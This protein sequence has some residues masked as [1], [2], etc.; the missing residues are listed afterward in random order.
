MTSGMASFEGMPVASQAEVDNAK[1]LA[2][3]FRSAS[4]ALLVVFV[5]ST[6][7]ALWLKRGD[8]WPWLS[9]FAFVVALGVLGFG[10]AFTV[11][12]SGLPIVLGIGAAGLGSIEIA[13]ARS[14]GRRPSFLSWTALGVA[15]AG[16][17]ANLVH[18]RGF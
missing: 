4:R 12:V 17:V 18:Q 14:L 8:A 16:L 15:A 10:L 5:A 11:G 6:G 9:V 1:R 7:T 13:G 2:R 3:F